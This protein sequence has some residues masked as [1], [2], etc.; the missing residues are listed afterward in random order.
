MPGTYFTGRK[1]NTHRSPNEIFIGAYFLPE[2]RKIAVLPF[3]AKLFAVTDEN[4]EK[5]FE[6]EVRHY[7]LDECSG[8]DVYIADLSTFRRPGTYRVTAE[9]KR[10]AVFHIAE[11]VHKTLLHD[12]LRA[13]YYMRCGCG[14][15]ERFAGVYAHEKCHTALAEIYDGGG[16]LDVTGGWHDAG[17]YGRYVTA[18]AVACAQLL[19]AYKLFPGVFESFCCD[20]PESGSGVPDILSECRVELEWLLKMQRPDGAVYHKATTFRHAP[21]VMPEND[22][23]KLWVFPPSSSAAAD[24]CAVC[25]LAAGIYGRYDGEFSERLKQ[26]ALL[27][28]GWLEKHPELV[29]FDNPDGCDTG[30]YGENDDRDNRYWASAELWALTGEER[31]YKTFHYLFETAFEGERSY[32]RTALGCGDVG[33]L[34][35]LAYILCERPERDEETAAKLK[36]GFYYEALWL[37]DKVKRSGYGAAMFEQDY[38][39]GSNMALLQNAMKFALAE[40][41]SGDGHFREL[42]E[43]QTAVLTGLNPLGICYI[44][45]HGEFRCGEP[46]FRPAAADGID[47]CIPG[48]VTGGPNRKLDDPRLREIIPPGT[49]PMKCF[50]DDVE[51]YSLCEV[52]IYWNSPAVFIYG[53]LNDK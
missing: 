38:Y 45:G 21:F 25:A 35:S 10:S 3:A 1:R 14:L 12:T 33:G 11:N 5:F 9:G 43:G 39:W 24:L 2:S 32:V 44:T 34:G 49:P 41:F 7:G 23:D 15:D 46:H 18:G 47:E 4:G 42:A 8:D 40:R 16:E 53:Y 48:F 20:I 51:C 31:F 22:N 17:D 37:E 52:T 28:Y 29:G 30:I 19:Y 36:D 50:A 6:G 13:F 26:A 27:A